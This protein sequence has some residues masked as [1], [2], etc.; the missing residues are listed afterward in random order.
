MLPD[1]GPPF[2]RQWVNDWRSGSP[3]RPQKRPVE[4][5]VSDVAQEILPDHQ[6]RICGTRT[7]QESRGVAS[8]ARQPRPG[9]GLPHLCNPVEPACRLQSA[10]AAHDGT[11]TTASPAFQPAFD[12]GDLKRHRCQNTVIQ[13]RLRVPAR[14]L[15]NGCTRF[16]SSTFRG[17]A[18]PGHCQ[19]GR[20]RSSKGPCTCRPPRNETP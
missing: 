18:S 1:D 8:D 20:H 12:D 10:V 9:D 13:R 2:R 4:G 17:P 11:D 15:L 14:S 19:R 6:L 3:K 5:E 16:F 7:K